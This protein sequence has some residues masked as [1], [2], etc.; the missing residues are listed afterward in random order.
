VSTL[1]DPVRLMVAGSLA[2]KARTVASIADYT[3]VEERDIVNA[4]GTLR[5]VGLVEQSDDGYTL[6]AAGLRRLA[7]ELAETDVP[8]DPWVGF[9]MSLDEQQILERFFQGRT[10]AEIPTNRAKRLL[11]LERISLEFD[12]GTR[13][14]EAAVND[15]L[16]GFHPDVAT[17]RRYLVDEG[18]L[19]REAGQYWRSGGRTD[20]N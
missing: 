3:G 5:Q 10:L 20:T 4:I 13:Y 12:L 6:P 16:H 18:R 11:V 19:D 1:L 15:V 2:G 17:L 9:G 14:T 8:M 7:S